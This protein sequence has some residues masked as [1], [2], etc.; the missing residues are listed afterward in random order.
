VEFWEEGE[1]RGGKGWSNSL[2][3]CYYNWGTSKKAP[4]MDKIFYKKEQGKER[5]Q[6]PRNRGILDYRVRNR[7]LI[8]GGTWSVILGTPTSREKNWKTSKIGGA[9]SVKKREVDWTVVKRQGQLKKC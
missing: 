5:G 2:I 6:A 1:N 9:K 8:K 7:Q 4:K 3:R